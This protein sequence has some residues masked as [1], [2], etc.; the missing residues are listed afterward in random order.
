MDLILGDVIL[1]VFHVDKQPVE[2][3][4]NILWRG[5]SGARGEAAGQEEF[6]LQLTVALQDHALQHGPVPASCCV[7]I[8]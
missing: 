6:S 3:A 4:E 2:A 7:A 5:A 1:A 8:E